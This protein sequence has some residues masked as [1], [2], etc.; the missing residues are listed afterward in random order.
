MQMTSSQEY[1]IKADENLMYHFFLSNN[2]SL[3]YSIYTNSNTVI[4]NTQL[5]PSILDFTV[6]IDKHK[7]IHLICITSEGELLYYINQNNQWNYKTISKLDIKSNIYRYLMLFV[8]GGYTHIIYNKTNLLSPMLSYIEHIYWNQNGINKAIV[9]NYIHGKHP[10]P[11]QISVDSLKNLHLVYKVYYKNNHQLYYSKF[12]IITQKWTNSELITNLLEDNSH[13]YIFIDRKDKI[14]MVWCTIEQNNFILKYKQRANVINKKSKWS[15]AQ[16]LSNKNSNTLSPIIIQESN[17]LKIYCKQ[18][19]KIVEIT[20]ENFGNTWGSSEEYLYD[21]DDPKIIKYSSCQKTDE[22]LF[23]QHVYGNI[24]NTIQTAGINLFKTTEDEFAFIDTKEDL[25]LEPNIC[26]DINSKDTNTYDNN[27]TSNTS[28]AAN[29]IGTTNAK[30]TTSTNNAAN[31]DDTTNTIDTANADDAASTNDTIN[32][33]DTTSTKIFEKDIANQIS[34]VNQFVKK[35]ETE[36]MTYSK[37]S[38][39]SHENQQSIEIVNELLSNC[40][41]LEKQLIEIEDEKQR[42][43]TAISEYESDLNL[44]EE[45]LIDYK[46]QM[47]ILQDK[48]NDITSHNSIFQRFINFFK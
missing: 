32:A 13:P 4:Q 3:H 31:A 12:N 2:K 42:L 14:H 25:I 38:E 11:L 34:E 15:H 19:S 18:N 44:L 37:D 22:D 29:T 26:D 35:E 27:N 48:L 6:T 28:D 20:S 43:A 10:S 33:N 36:N 8:Q 46:K 39:P 41:E 21:I 9:G 47:L 45:K 7:K 1:L 17:I 30:D 23:I 5:V 24:N 40:K 16:T